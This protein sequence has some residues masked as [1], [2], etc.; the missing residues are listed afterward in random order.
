MASGLRYRPVAEKAAIIAEVVRHLWPL[1]ESG[2]V[3]PVVHEVLPMREAA[4][5]HQ[6]MTDGNPFGKLILTV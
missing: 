5:A 2:E 6:I 1:I 4:R 3:R